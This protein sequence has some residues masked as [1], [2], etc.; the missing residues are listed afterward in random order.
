MGVQG[1]EG[2]AMNP[3]SFEPEW[4]YIEV[5]AEVLGL[6]KEDGVLMVTTVKGTF[7]LDPRFFETEDSKE[8]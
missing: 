4:N 7:P 6:R 5:G 8:T 1:R 2:Q 3:D